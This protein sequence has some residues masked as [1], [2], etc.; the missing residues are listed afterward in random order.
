MIKKEQEILG[1]VAEEAVSK[2]MYFATNFNGNCQVTMSNFMSQEAR[3]KGLANGVKEG[4][5]IEMTEENL[6]RLDKINALVYEMVTS[7]TGGI[8]C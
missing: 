8:K 5:T 6:E 2:T 3:D 4:V 1:V 7:V